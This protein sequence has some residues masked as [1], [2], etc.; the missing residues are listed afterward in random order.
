MATGF[1][2]WS[3]KKD[4]DI[5]AEELKKLGN[6]DNKISVV[7]EGFRLL[8]EALTAPKEKDLVEAF[9]DVTTDKTTKKGKKQW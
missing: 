9:L 4:D 3:V 7:R 5:E 8:R 2:H 1:T 6:F